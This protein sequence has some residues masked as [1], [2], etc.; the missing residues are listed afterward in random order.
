MQHESRSACAFRSLFCC[1]LDFAMF[2]SCVCL[3]SQGLLFTPLFLFLFAPSFRFSCE[4][5][6]GCSWMFAGHLSSADSGTAEQFLCAQT[7]ARGCYSLTTEESCTS[8]GGAAQRR[9]LLQDQASCVGSVMG[10]WPPDRWDLDT[11]AQ[12][13]M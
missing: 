12:I 11:A 9:R 4:L 6:S 8:G 1:V 10:T 5:Q 3:V 13:P 2:G 7:A